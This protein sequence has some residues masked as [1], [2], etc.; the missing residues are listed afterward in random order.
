MPSSLRS[1]IHSGPVKRS[2]VSVAAIGSSHSGNG[3][4]HGSS[5]AEGV[6]RGNGRQP[7]AVVRR[8]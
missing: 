6:K 8:K 4:V 5:V 2:C 1:K 3:I 7:V